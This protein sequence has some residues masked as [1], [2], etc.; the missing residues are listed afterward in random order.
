MAKGETATKREKAREERKR[1]EQRRVAWRGGK[2]G[3][4]AFAIR[5]TTRARSSGRPSRGDGTCSELVGLARPCA[6]VP[7]DVLVVGEPALVGV[8]PGVEGVT[9]LHATRGSMERKRASS[10]SREFW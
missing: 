2:E 8:V 5:R 10:S 3:K 6:C 7:V 4:E 1:S 9:G